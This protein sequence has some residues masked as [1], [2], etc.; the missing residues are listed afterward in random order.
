MEA[1]KRGAQREARGRTYGRV[2]QSTYIGNAQTENLTKKGLAAYE[3]KF[4][5]EIFEFL[6]FFH[7]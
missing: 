5:K 6:P 1:K 3:C 2:E 7:S 4:L